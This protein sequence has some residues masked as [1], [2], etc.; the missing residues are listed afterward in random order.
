MAAGEDPSVTVGN[1][2]NRVG[3]VLRQPPNTS[4]TPLRSAS[5]GRVARWGIGALLSP[6]AT[7]Q[8]FGVA[9]E[10]VG[11]GA[12]RLGGILDNF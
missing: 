9:L 4:R 3:G 10:H 2:Y 7:E 8:G 5:T 6:F 11:Q 12:D 1:R